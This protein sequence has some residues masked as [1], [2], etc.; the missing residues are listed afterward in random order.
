[1]VRW[2]RAFTTSA[3]PAQ[4]LPTNMTRVAS[5]LTPRSLAVG[6]TGAAV[7]GYTK[8][9][10]VAVAFFELG[11][12]VATTAREARIL[13]QREASDVIERL[14]AAIEALKAGK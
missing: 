14:L 8:D 11:E 7:E 2:V 3:V 1:M 4:L 12:D 13:R 10:P 5:P 9:G 6:P